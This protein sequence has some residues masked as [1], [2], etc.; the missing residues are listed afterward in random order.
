MWRL[1]KQRIAF[2]DLFLNP[3]TKL[4]MEGAIRDSSARQASELN[5]IRKLIRKEESVNGLKPPQQ[6]RGIIF[7]SSK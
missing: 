2:Q 7:S 4:G 1:K 3:V 6:K 5:P